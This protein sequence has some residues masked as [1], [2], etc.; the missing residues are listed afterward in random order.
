MCPPPLFVPASISPGAAVT[1]WATLSAITFAAVTVSLPEGNLSAAFTLFARPGSGSPARTTGKAPRSAPN[2]EQ[3]SQIGRPYFRR[4]ERTIGLA[5]RDHQ[6]LVGQRIGFLTLPSLDA[7]TG[8][9]PPGDETG[10]EQVLDVCTLPCSSGMFSRSVISV[11]LRGPSPRICRIS[12]AVWLP[13]AFAIFWARSITGFEEHDIVCH[14]SRLSAAMIRSRPTFK[15]RSSR[16]VSVLRPVPSWAFAP[17]LPPH[18][19]RP[20]R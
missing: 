15:A 13:I 4:S 5:G 18:A 20:A 6:Q 14:N 1:F 7:V 3:R 12:L 8:S 2:R 11:R 19:R 9:A 10:I 17:P 16:A